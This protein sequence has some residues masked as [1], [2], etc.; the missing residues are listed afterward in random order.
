[1]K[2]HT[3][4]P[5]FEKSFEIRR[6]LKFRIKGK[7]QEGELVIGN[8]RK[9]EIK[10]KAPSFACSWSLSPTDPKPRDIYG[11][12]ALSALVNCL[13]FL[14]AYVQNYAEAGIEIWWVE[15]GDN[16]GLKPFLAE[17][18]GTKGVVPPNGV[19]NFGRCRPRQ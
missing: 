3:S 19:K 17:M 15:K 13:A 1:M 6:V 12:D 7:L 2:P 11:E 16:A 10:G 4:K 18:P 5:T 9:V 14:N 8:L